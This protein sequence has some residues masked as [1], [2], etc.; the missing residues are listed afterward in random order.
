MKNIEKQNDLL[1]LAVSSNNYIKII[2]NSVN[3]EIIKVEEVSSVLEINKNQEDYNKVLILCLSKNFTIIP[4]SLYSKDNEKHYIDFTTSENAK[5]NKVLVDNIISEKINI[6]WTLNKE[7]ESRFKQ[8]YKGAI[9]KNILPTIITNSIAY[10]KPNKITSLFLKTHL[11]IVV[12]VSD[13]I[14]IVNRFKIKSIE[15]ALYYHL[16]MLQISELEE[17]NIH[18][19]TGGVFKD[20]DEFLD[21]LSNYFS[22]IERIKSKHTQTNINLG[23]YEIDKF[24]NNIYL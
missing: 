2:K 24:C 9:V 4:S 8:Y 7:E 15:D 11:V 14:K 19:K 1:L 3:K 22:N 16:L 21:R 10:K 5:D 13:K 18:I 20:I 6:I 12:V 17:S 23:I